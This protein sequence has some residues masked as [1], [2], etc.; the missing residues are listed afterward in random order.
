MNIKKIRVIVPLLL[1][2]ALCLSTAGC[3]A[4]GAFAFLSKESKEEGDPLLPDNSQSSSRE[5]EKTDS[6]EI[7]II[8]EQQDPVEGTAEKG[9][10]GLSG[11]HYDQIPEEE[12]KVYEQLYTGISERKSEFYITADSAENVGPALRAL[13]ADHPEF[14]WLTGSASIYGFPGPGIKRITLEFNI[15]PADIDSQQA[16]IE[17]EAA[18]YLGQLYDGMSEYEKVRLAYEYVI[19]N[20]DYVMGAQQSQNIQ[21]SMIYHESVC[22]GYAREFQYLLANAGVFCAYV[23]GDITDRTSGSMEAHA[24][25]LVMIDGEYTYVDP[26]W[27]DPNYTSEEQNDM[28]PEVTYSYLCLTSDDLARSGYQPTEEYT[29][30]ETYSRTWDYYVLNGYYHEYYNYDEIYT[31]LIDAINNGADSVHMKFSDFDNYSAAKGD[32]YDGELLSTA[33]QHKMSI[34]GKGTMSYYPVNEDA[35]YTIDIY[36]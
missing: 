3:S 4:D 26:T 30:P 18:G 35:L 27:G 24:W 16:L 5:G 36:W 8:E 6:E 21:S 23:E 29:I 10:E 25:N 1:S 20:T 33:L 2:T 14:F 28:A 31:M 12:R 32:L 22:A 19:R 17:A 11:F 15:D 13:L 9:T 7:V 34:E